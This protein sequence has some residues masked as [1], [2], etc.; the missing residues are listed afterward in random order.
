[1]GYMGLEF[2]IF[3]RGANKNL[4]RE[5]ERKKGKKRLETGKRKIERKEG[6]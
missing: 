2:F 6:K 5:G 4:E 3:I 1:M